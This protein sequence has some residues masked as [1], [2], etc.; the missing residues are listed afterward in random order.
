MRKE[1]I[2]TISPQRCSK[3]ELVCGDNRIELIRYACN[4]ITVSYQYKFL[5]VQEMD[6]QTPLSNLSS[7][8][9][10]SLIS[11]ITILG[12][13]LLLSLSVIDTEGCR[14][15]VLRIRH[16]LASRH[17]RDLY[18]YRQTILQILII[19]LVALI[20]S[21]TDALHCL[22]RRISETFVYGQVKCHAERKDRNHV[23]EDF[24]QS[25]TSGSASLNDFKRVIEWVLVD[26]YSRKE[27][28]W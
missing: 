24:V 5:F 21:W 14:P 18:W 20:S 19:S 4:A 27:A 8:E 11:S 10:I 13:S 9:P 22:Q 6:I 16:K 7:G 15:N 23:K 12:R 28:L 17:G 26:F 3:S 2:C 25:K 1:D